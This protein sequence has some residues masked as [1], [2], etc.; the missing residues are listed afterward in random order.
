MNQLNPSSSVETLVDKYGWYAVTRLDG[1]P[2]LA[3][4]AADARTMNNDLDQAY[5]NPDVNVREL[6]R[7]R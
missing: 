7:P 2:D 4:V 5:N 1:N 6:T 3:G